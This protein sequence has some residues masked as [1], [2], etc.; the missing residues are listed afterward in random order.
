MGGSFNFKTGVQ[1][2]NPFRGPVI[3]GYFHGRG[4]IIDRTWHSGYE[5]MWYQGIAYGNLQSSKRGYRLLSY[6]KEHILVYDA[7]RV[8]AQPTQHKIKIFSQAKAREKKQKPLWESVR[9]MFTSVDAMVLSPNVLVAAER[10]LFDVLKV[11][12]ADRTLE[13]EQK[14][15]AEVLLMST[16]DGKVMQTLAL[17]S[18]IAA[19]GL[20]VTKDRLLVSCMDGTVICFEEDK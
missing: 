20:A 7:P 10:T 5:P 13:D 2:G 8:L 6:N 9:P 19:D 11:K 17:Q 1:S 12:M 3:Q 16:A 18:P 4:H 15:K 14:L